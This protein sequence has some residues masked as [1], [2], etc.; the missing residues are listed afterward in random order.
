MKRLISFFIF[1]ASLGF[2]LY[3]SSIGIGSGP[4][5]RGRQCIDYN[6]ITTC[7]DIVACTYNG[8][9]YTA[10][11]GFAGF[12]ECCTLSLAPP[13]PRETCTGT[14]SSCSNPPPPPP[15]GVGSGGP[16]TH[17]Q[18]CSGFGGS[19]SCFE[20][21]L[22]HSASY[23]IFPASACCPNTWGNNYGSCQG[24]HPTCPH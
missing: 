22:C 4:C 6:D 23:A 24:T 10:P 5:Q 3:S 15:P 1:I 12:D 13:D 18:N 8:Q 20:W 14:H 16:C 19:Y 21:A 7:S 9:T 11:I 17:Q 2:F